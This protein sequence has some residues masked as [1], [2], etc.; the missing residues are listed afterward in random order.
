MSRNSVDHCPAHFRRNLAFRALLPFFVNTF[1]TLINEL[2]IF[3]FYLVAH[4]SHQVPAGRFGFI[5]L[6]PN[7][8]F[9]VEV[10]TQACKRMAFLDRVG[11]LLDDNSRIFT[12]EEGREEH[13][14]KENEIK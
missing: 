11:L 10:S 14:N 3:L 4:R 6:R 9:L 1:A 8:T 12:A 5:L 13:E 2:L 7:F